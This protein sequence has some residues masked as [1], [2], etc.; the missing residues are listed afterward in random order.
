MKTLPPVRINRESYL[1]LEQ[2]TRDTLA[3]CR[4]EAQDGTPL[5]FPDGSGHYPAL[6]TRDFCYMAEGAAQLMAADDILA[7][8][9]YL[10]AAQREDGYI[11]DRVQADGLA[12]FF[13]GPVD[14]PIGSLPPVDNQPFMAKLICAYAARSKDYRRARER[15][16]H[17]Y[18]AMDAVPREADGL[19][20]V[21]RNNS[22]V[23]YGFT[24]CIRKTGKTLMGSLL[25]WEACQLVAETYQK[26]EHHDDARDWFERAEHA[27]HRLFEF[28]DDD[29]GMFRAAMGDNRI[30][31]IWGSAYAA[32]LRVSSKTQ[33]ERI[34]Y[35]L[36]RHKGEI[37]LNGYVRHLPG[38]EYWHKLF[39]DVPRDTYQNGGFWAV[40]SGW[41]ART[42]ATVDE[43]YANKMME[44]LI[45]HFAEHGACEWISPDQNV[46]PQYG[47]SAACALGSVTPKKG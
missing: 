28:W 7:G 25:Y 15:M 18:A 40:P 24:D 30:V 29:Q 3:A 33:T 21:D 23:D 31:D 12:V 44:W 5:Y 42:I 11:P 13:P 6:W 26:W 36:M 37:L 41:V 20:A 27:G 35:Y 46:L 10:L 32:V 45:A 47:A 14:K 43:D 9:D 16:D 2:T 39:V 1:K 4:H 8:I 22:W 17:V 38:G 34:A 19:V